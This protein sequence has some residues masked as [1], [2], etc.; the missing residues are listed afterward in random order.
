MDSR[1]FFNYTTLWP[2]TTR[3]GVLQR[4]GRCGVP[5]KALKE[6]SEVLVPSQGSATKQLCDLQEWI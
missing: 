3:G 5:G 2:H 4:K 1:S 6:E